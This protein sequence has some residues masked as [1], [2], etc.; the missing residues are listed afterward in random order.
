MRYE[1]TVSDYGRVETMTVG[2]DWEKDK[3]PGDIVFYA[4]RHAQGYGRLID[5]RPVRERV[6]G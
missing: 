5:M 4:N 1:V 6:M 3:K 2:E